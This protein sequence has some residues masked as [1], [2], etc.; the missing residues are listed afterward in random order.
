[1]VELGDHGV[2]EVYEVGAAPGALGAQIFDAGLEMGQFGLVVVWLVLDDA[3]VLEAGH[4]QGL[5]VCVEFLE[6]FLPGGVAGEEV[7]GPLAL[8]LEFG[9]AGTGLVFGGAVDGFI[10]RA[11][12]VAFCYLA[13]GDE[14]QALVE[15]GEEDVS[16]VG[17]CPDLRSGRANT[18]CASSR[19]MLQVLASLRALRYDPSRRKL[20]SSCGTYRKLL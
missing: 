7:Y 17:A 5:I 20:V 4:V 11:F 10:T 1:V 9:N 8:G 13:E 12:Q 19:A 18:R 14:V 15:L 3:E 6:V 16:V 2:E